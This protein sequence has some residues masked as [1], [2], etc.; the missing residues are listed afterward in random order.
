MPFSS[1]RLALVGRERKRAPA[2][3]VPAATEGEAV[4]MTKVETVERLVAA[5][6]DRFGRLDAALN[7]AGISHPPSPLVD[8]TVEQFDAVQRTNL[9]GVFL[10]MKYE[11][12]AM[13]A[14]G[15]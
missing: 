2:G 12:P 9:R 8:L 10:A 14:N 3:G 15:G 4:A 6:L 13:I 11:I 7:N 1:S 5:T